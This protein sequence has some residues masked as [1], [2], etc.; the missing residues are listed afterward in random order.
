M[1]W[2]A[3]QDLVAMIDWALTTPS[4][5]GPLNATSPKPVSSRDLAKELGRAIHRPAVIPAPWLALRVVMGEVATPMCASLRVS[6]RKAISE[7]FV[8]HLPELA[9]AMP[10]VLS[11]DR[12][13]FQSAQSDHNFPL[14]QPLDGVKLVAFD[15]DGAIGDDDLLPPSLEDRIA[16]FAK[17]SISVAIATRRTPTELRTLLEGKVETGFALACDG[18]AAVDLRDGSIPYTQAIPAT[19]A[20]ELWRAIAA[21]A[22]GVIGHVDHSR[23]TIR[24]AGGVEDG[25]IIEL[26]KDRPILRLSITGP[27][28]ALHL[29]YKA[30]QAPWQRREIALL[31]DHLGS[32]DILH[33][34]SD[35]GVAIQEVARG[36]GIPQ[37]ATVAIAGTG[38][39]AG[40][41]EWSG[42]A[43]GVAGSPQAIQD[44]AQL[45]TSQRGRAGVEEIF[46]RLL[47]AAKAR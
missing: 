13:M 24:C 30:I 34:M 15:L 47:L 27:P 11:G 42:I 14:D 12:S 31:S 43:V 44:L 46:D 25:A 16:A 1:P 33:P 8:F 2:I 6:P 22:P 28:S 40:L 38:R 19:Q 18:A 17:R 35:R 20:A 7:G 45:T 9:R 10:A 5:R 4:V 36:Q 32:I 23:G 37:S 41:L 26:C 39:S 21:A 29:A 3:W